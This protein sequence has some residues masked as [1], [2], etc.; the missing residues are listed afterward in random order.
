MDAVRGLIREYTRTM[1]LDLGF[2]GLEEELASLPGK[3]AEPKGALLVAE[4][5]GEICGCVALR[6]LGD[7]ICEMKRLY[8]E[9]GR[10][11]LGVGRG[12]VEAVLAAAK[13]KGYRKMRLDSLERMQAAVGLYHAFGFRETRPYVYNPIEGALFMEKDLG[14]DP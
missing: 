2:Q 6:D 9:E 1:G 14:E 3:Y 7:G 5:D 8:V 12:L 4:S 13:G 10:K 11:G